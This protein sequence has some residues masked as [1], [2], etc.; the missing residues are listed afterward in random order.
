MGSF[1]AEKQNTHTFRGINPQSSS[2]EMDLI[3]KQLHV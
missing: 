1:P 2:Q 3:Q